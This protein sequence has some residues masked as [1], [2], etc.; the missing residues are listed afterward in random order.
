MNILISILYVSL[1]CFIVIKTNQIEKHVKAKT[2]ALSMLPSIILMYIISYLNE[3]V[4]EIVAI[5]L[6]SMFI[7]SIAFRIKIIKGLV[8]SIIFI[9]FY[10]LCEAMTHLIFIKLL[11]FNMNDIISSELIYCLYKLMSF[12]MISLLLNM[13]KSV[14][15]YNIY[16][17][18][19]DFKAKFASAIILIILIIIIIVNFFI[20]SKIND[21]SFTFILS[22]VSFG[23]STLIC[24]SLFYF[25]NIIVDTTNNLDLTKEYN[26]K[27]EIYNKTMQELIDVQRKTVHEFNNKLTVL[28][29]YIADKKYD[30]ASIFVSKSLKETKNLDNSLFKNIK[31]SGL[32][33]LLLFKYAEIKDKNIGFE[34]M[35]N[36]RIENLIVDS[37]DVCK[38]L[39]IF[40]DNAIEAAA[41]SKNPFISIGIVKIEE[42]INITIMNSIPNNQLN[43]NQNSQKTRSEELSI[44]KMYQEGYSKKGYN[45]GF[46]L[47]IAKD[48]IDRYKE[49]SCVTEIRDSFFIQDLSISKQ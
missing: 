43:T 45:R 6:I 4:I 14:D 44:D 22:V 2:I 13:D 27:L 36:K 26:N 17:K 32:K 47:S 24:M 48:L 38:I 18:S 20:V 30:D 12:V 23:A 8:F 5:F 11:G 39:G 33:S 35:V 10:C 1:I 7:N 15:V 16:N 40:I 46:G 19:L 21:N 41:N 34:L 25:I 9:T 29:G 49:L 37:D 42:A 31:N 3:T 28:N